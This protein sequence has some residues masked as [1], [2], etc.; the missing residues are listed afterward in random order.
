MRPMRL[1]P[2]RPQER[3]CARSSRRRPRDG[4]RAPG[5][6]RSAASRTSEKLRAWGFDDDSRDILHAATTWIPSL[7]AVLARA[8]P[9]DTVPGLL[10]VVATVAELG[11]GYPTATNLTR[12]HPLRA[13]GDA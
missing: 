7:R 12:H 10:I 2:P 6:R 13:G 3:S 8:R 9:V 4:S 1:R 5:V 11:A